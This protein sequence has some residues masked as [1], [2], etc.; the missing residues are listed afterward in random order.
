[1]LSGHSQ[2]AIAGSIGVAPRTVANQIASVYRKVNVHS[3]MDLFVAL[4]RV[5]AG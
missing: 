3:R 5:D 4:S 1:M 2:A